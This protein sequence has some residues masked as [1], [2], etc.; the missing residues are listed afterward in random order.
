[1]TM[2]TRT[3]SSLISFRRDRQNPLTPNFD[4]VYALPPAAGYRAFME[5]TAT[6]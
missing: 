2:V 5:E 6:T 1:M 3:S 4:A